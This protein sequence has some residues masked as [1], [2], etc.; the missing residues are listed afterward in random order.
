MP[1]QKYIKVITPN[2]FIKKT[3]HSREE[4]FST[5][6]PPFFSHRLVPVDRPYHLPVVPQPPED[7]LHPLGPGFRGDVAREGHE[8]AL[9][10][11]LEGPLAAEGRVAAVVH[12]RGPTGTPINPGARNRWFKIRGGVL[13]G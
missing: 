13:R 11:A 9:R 1:N 10:V 12:R 4:F 7:L 6:H 5:L 3:P 8:E 2:R